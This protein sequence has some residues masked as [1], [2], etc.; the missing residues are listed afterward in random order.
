M[1]DVLYIVG[2]GSEHDNLELRWSLRSLA[3]YAKNLGRVVV[4]GYPPAFLSD[5]VVRLPLADLSDDYKHHNILAAILAAIDR[6]VVRGDFLYSSDDHFLT[7]PADLDAWPFYYKGEM[8]P[9]TSDFR[10]EPTPY[11]KSLIST[12]RLL[13]AAGLEPRNWSS[14]CNTHMHTADAPRVRELLQLGRRLGLSRFGY[15]PT[16]LFMACRAAREKITPTLR[17]DVKIGEQF[18]LPAPSPVPFTFIDAR[19]AIERFGLSAISRL[20]WHGRPASPM[21][22]FRVAA[23]LLPELADVDKLLYCD[24]D[25][26]FRSPRFAEVF[27]LDVP[28]DMTAVPDAPRFQELASLNSQYFNSGVLL[29]DLRNMRRNHPELE[30]MIP[31]WTDVAVERRFKF[32]DQDVINKFCYVSPMPHAFNVMPRHYAAGEDAF[33]VHYASKDKLTGG[34]PPAELA[35]RI[36]ASK[37]RTGASE[38]R[39]SASETRTGAAIL[40]CVDGDLRAHGWLHYALE[41]LARVAPPGLRVFIASDSPYPGELPPSISISDAA[42]SSKSF[43][44][45]TAASFPSPSTFEVS[46]HAEA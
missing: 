45:W 36:G 5:E 11:Q 7:A 4:A 24:I 40:F 19:P 20:R 14:H 32:I 28:G 43:L 13:E 10:T 16:C 29:M 41:T 31:Q 25:V 26:D 6:G 22:L 2:R 18:H 8:L 34:Y 44:S 42:F 38:T 39:T 15:E 21:Q 17:R 35:T 27:D 33:I 46:A 30:R 9:E 23:P 1:T 37:T 12:R 3:K